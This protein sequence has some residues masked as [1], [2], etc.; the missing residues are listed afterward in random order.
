MA[1]ILH[2]VNLFVIGFFVGW[3][4]YPLVQT[5]KKIWQN[6]KKATDNERKD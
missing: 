5:F 3:V 1:E 6:A 2:D 4:A